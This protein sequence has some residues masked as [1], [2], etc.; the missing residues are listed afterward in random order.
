MTRTSPTV[1]AAAC[2]LG[3]ML[4]GLLPGGCSSSDRLTQG[5]GGSEVSAESGKAGAEASSDAGRPATAGGNAG[6]TAA[7]PSSGGEGGDAG[8]EGNLGNQP[9]GGG[10]STTNKCGSDSDCVQV[11]GSCFVCEV[12]GVAK[13]C[14]D[15]GPPSCDNGVLEPCEV[16]ELGQTKPC[17]ELG[18][19]GEFSGG[20][21][22]CLV[23]CAGWN[24][25][26]CSVC[27]NAQ[28]E[29]DEECEGTPI[30]PHTCADEGLAENPTTA[31]PCTDE[32]RFDTTLCG[33]CSKDAL[34][35]LQGADC[36]GAACNGAECA[37]G[38]R[39]KLDCAGGGNHCR[40]LRCNHDASCDYACNTRGGCENVV[41]DSAAGCA[42]HCSG[43]N[44]DGTLCKAGADCSFDCHGT[45]SCK[46]I[47]CRP[48]SDC[49]FDCDGAGPHCSGQ[50][51]CGA[52]KACSFSC[53]EGSDCS[54][55]A[56][57]CPS[58]A[59]CTFT[60]QGSGSVCPHAECLEGSSCV[61]SC[62]DG[63]CNSPTCERGAC[64]GN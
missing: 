20:M 52:G 7:Q 19:R 34:S 58:G 17:S 50:V 31:L 51:T 35:C 53:S 64:S 4:S 30:E 62:A 3:L 13:D 8:A 12:S 45:G 33:G 2:L 9:S 27:G 18:E 15:K 48:G 1:G 24:T 11:E 38:S 43:G 41:C 49:D 42:L 40:D 39:C 16:C 44:C 22:K 32:C 56:V 55:L 6:S 25:S 63:D 28:L 14:V 5:V 57:T 26:S 60:C 10:T 54:G 23:T 59:A 61:F 36:E 47:L 29:A 37:I 46:D 21:A